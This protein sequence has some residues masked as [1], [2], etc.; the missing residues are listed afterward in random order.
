MMSG[1]TNHLGMSKELLQQLRERNVLNEALRDISKCPRNADNI[2]RRLLRLNQ[3][4]DIRQKELD[5]IRLHNDKLPYKI[6]SKS[7]VDSSVVASFKSK[8]GYLYRL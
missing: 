2:I 8:A 3:E 1:R 5:V 4:S 7:Y 6:R